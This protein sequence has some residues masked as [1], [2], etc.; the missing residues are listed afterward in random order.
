MD[1]SGIRKKL[2]LYIDGM[3]DE[4]SL[5]AVE[6]HL[7]SCE[8]CR[9]ELAALKEIIQIAGD[10]ETVEPPK[11]LHN[12]ILQA[13][14]IEQQAEKTLS[15]MPGRWSITARL[16]G[17]VSRRG[18]QWAAGV[19]AAGCLALVIMIGTPHET[20]R[21]R[22]TVVSKKANIAA[23]RTVPVVKPSVNVTKSEVATTEPVPAP[24]NKALH[25]RVKRS[26]LAAAH[27]R[28]VTQKKQADV[29][30]R[31]ALT[32]KQTDVIHQ[33]PEID[34][35]QA[36]TV[37]VAALETNANTSEVEPV[38]IKVAAVPDLS[39]EKMHEWMQ[40]AKVQA[41][42]RKSRVQS[43]VVNIVSTKF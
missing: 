9:N 33:E 12:N 10:I 19:V 34:E 21:S 37:E 15:K 18:M 42:M 25:S 17:C 30:A 5:E 41:E 11:R 4:Q 35:P 38:A 1:C 31:T 40:Q 6:A 28:H 7:A 24:T 14:A 22:Q 29:I 27:K 8:D 13:I 3:L 39:N 2:S 16:G 23:S 36:D 32:S 26:N 43:G 20:N